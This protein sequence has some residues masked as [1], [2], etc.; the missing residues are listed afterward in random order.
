MMFS[1]QSEEVGFISQ[2]AFEEACESLHRLHVH[3]NRAGQVSELHG[4]VSICHLS[5]VIIP[6]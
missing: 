2:H 3:K 1:D 6:T 4:E 5:E